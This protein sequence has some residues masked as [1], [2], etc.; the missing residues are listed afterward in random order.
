MTQTIQEQKQPEKIVWNVS[1]KSR[2]PPTLEQAKIKSRS[3][4][5]VEVFVDKGISPSKSP[6]DL[7]KRFVK[8]YL[9][10]G[11]ELVEHELVAFN[12]DNH[13]SEKD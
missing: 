8:Q 6:T 11:G 9:Y 2:I 12:W 10:E 5:Q 3:G 7:H 4:V 1:K 13:L